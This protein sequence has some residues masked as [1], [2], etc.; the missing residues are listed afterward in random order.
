MRTVTARLTRRLYGRL[1]EL[2]DQMNDLKVRVVDPSSDK[3]WV[4]LM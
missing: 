1:S 3:E 2:V 4:A